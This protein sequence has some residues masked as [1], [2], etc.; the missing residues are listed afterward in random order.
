MSA[1]LCQIWESYLSVVISLMSSLRDNFVMSSHWWHLS[2]VI[3]LMTSLKS[4]LINS[5]SW[6]P[7]WE[8]YLRELSLMTDMRCHHCEITTECRLSDSWSWESCH[9]DIV[10]REILLVTIDK[11]H[12]SDGWHMSMDH[13]VNFHNVGHVSVISL[14]HDH[15][16]RHEKA[17]TEI[18]HWDIVIKMSLRCHYWVSLSH[19]R[20]Q[21]VISL[22]VNM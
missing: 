8:S 16:V 1:S 12:L 18:C 19:V 11:S 3:S 5:W 9:W 13:K 22:M 4:Y 6:S 15:E 20:H 7:T 14:F 2:D 17:I 21:R 10:I